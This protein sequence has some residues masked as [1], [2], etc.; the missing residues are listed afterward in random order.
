MG[1][2][3]VSFCL[4]TYRRSQFL[5]KTLRLIARQTM[6]DFEVIVSDNDPAGTS[7]SVVERVNDS[8]FR[9]FCN[10]TNLGMVKNFNRALERATGQFV[11]MITDDDPPHANLLETLKSIC[12]EYPGYGAYY[13]AC[14][15]L[16]ED[17]ELARFY[18]TKPGKITWLA[19]V[20]Q[21]SVRLFSAK[22]FPNAY[23]TN[24][25]FPY[26][27]WSTGMV[28]RDIALSIGG[29]P[30]YGSPYL[31]DVAYIA[32]AG[33]WAGCATINV[34]LGYQT[35]HEGNFG[36]KE[37]GQ[38]YNAVRGCYEYLARNLESRKDWVSLDKTV[39]NYLGRW[40]INHSL[41]LLKYFHK[42]RDNKRE[43]K[44][45]LSKIF[46]LPYMRSVRPRY[47]L[48][49]RMPWLL[50]PYRFVRSSLGSGLRMLRSA[51]RAL[52]E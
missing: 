13:G 30:D 24:K 4:A 44:E 37:C 46:H 51:G 28:R 22:E 35:V 19:N 33:S 11:I 39:R 42:N 31:T 15:V 16:I 52:S 17:A 8:R 32:L 29:M 40:A 38:L 49:V 20:P 47:F 48:Q 9:Y 41:F 27:L 36:R 26:V 10:S 6:P 50:G 2:P 23:F 34:P 12:A 14:E 25:I 1:V 21:G 7:R 43:L 45:T 18:G 5:E 3:F